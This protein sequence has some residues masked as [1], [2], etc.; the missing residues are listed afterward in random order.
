MRKAAAAAADAAAAFEPDFSDAF[1]DLLLVSEL[2]FC[3]L[4]SLFPFASDHPLPLCSC[5]RTIMA[6]YKVR[7][8]SLT[9]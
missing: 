1:A 3:N 9:A 4:F 5:I 7:R 8:S 6:F 2:R